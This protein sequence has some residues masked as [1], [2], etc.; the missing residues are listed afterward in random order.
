MRIE[1]SE[2]GTVRAGKSFA[3]ELKEQYAAGLLGLKGFSHV[4][5]VW[6]ADKAPAWS[7]ASLRMDKPYRLA[8]EKLGVFATRSPHRP[9]SVCVSVAAVSSI[10]ERK[11]IIK[12]WWTDAGDGTP[13]LD[14]KPYHPCSDRVRDAILP[15]WCAAWPACYEDSAAFPWENEF[16]FSRARSGATGM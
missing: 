15:E 11:G 5:I 6:Y 3:V 2:I 1:L 14:I 4:M 12:L 10:D 9:S 13:V 7:S 16:R 8:P